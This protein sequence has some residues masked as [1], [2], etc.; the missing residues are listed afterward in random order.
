ME[1]ESEEYEEF[2]DVVPRKKQSKETRSLVANKYETEE[3]TAEQ[4]V[5]EMNKM[6]AA[7]SIMP[8]VQYQYEENF[9]EDNT[10][11]D[12]FEETTINVKTD[13]FVVDQEIDDQFK[14]STIKMT[15]DKDNQLYE[16]E[17]EQENLNLL[18]QGFNLRRAANFLS[19]IIFWWVTTLA[20][21]AKK[22]PLEQKDTFGLDDN[23]KSDVTYN[24]FFKEQWENSK[25]SK[26]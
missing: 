14:T 23:N 19:K 10:I 26:K 20:R 7:P 22:R 25:S 24:K 9:L 1:S 21:T 12:Q 5:D 6:Y 2:Q 15:S 16:A 13:K 11:K 17:R 18:E 4:S 3:E 8:N